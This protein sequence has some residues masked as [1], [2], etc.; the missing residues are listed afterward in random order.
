MLKFKKANAVFLCYFFLVPLFPNKMF[1]FF[2]VFPVTFFPFT[3]LVVDLPCD[4][5][6]SVSTEHLSEWF[7]VINQTETEQN[8][9]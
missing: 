1:Y 9:V 5:Q 4:G 8:I 2:L 3:A 7:F 6:S